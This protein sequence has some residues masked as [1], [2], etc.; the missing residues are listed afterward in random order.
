VKETL[1]KVAVA[2]VAACAASI[3]TALGEL[4]RDALKER[5]TPKPQPKRRR[6]GAR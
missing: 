5:L 4:A 1:K 2:L 6:R 3:G